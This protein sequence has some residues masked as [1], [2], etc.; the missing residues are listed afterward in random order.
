MPAPRVNPWEL[1][2]VQD[3]E[4]PDYEASTPPAYSSGTY[5]EPLV[6]YHLRQYDRKI[7][8]LL[9]YDTATSSSYR[10]TT[11]S[12]K[13]FSKKPDMEVLYTSEDMRQR[14]IAK[15]RFDSDGPLP[16]CPRAHFDY[17]ETAG[18][19]ATYKMES[20]N[21]TDWAIP[22]G[23][24]SYEWSITINP[25]ALVLKQ[26]NSD[27]VAAHFMYSECGT[28]AVRG[29]EVGELSVFRDRLTQEMGGVDKVVCSFMVALTHLK[30]MGRCYRNTSTPEAMRA[31]SMTREH[32]HSHRAS[33]AGLSVV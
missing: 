6:V 10:I 31:G 3:E 9:S 17:T 27:M 20:R 33:S 14:N 16:W 7:Q 32:P 2:I 29:A 18:A 13:L 5:D 4:L 26:S 30:R 24:Q 28:Q 25:S 15:I 11:N 19:A 21:F 22:L 8:M 23:E 12:F 1:E